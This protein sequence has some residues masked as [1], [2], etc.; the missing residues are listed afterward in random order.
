M[1]HELAALNVLQHKVDLVVVLKRELEVA[2]EG[3]LHRRQN[4][5]LHQRV[6]H[7]HRI[8]VGCVRA[9]VCVL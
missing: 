9:C 4:Q 8:A 2:D 7:V 3:M 1:V 5:P 6:V